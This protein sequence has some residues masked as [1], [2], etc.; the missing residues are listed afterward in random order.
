MSGPTILGVDPSLT[1]TATCGPDGQSIIKSKQTG[2]ARLH[3]I[4]DAVVALAL[5]V[6]VVYIEGYSMGRQSNALLHMGEL[7]GALRLSFWR[8]NIPYVEVPPSTL[9]KF[10]TG[11]GNANKDLVVSAVTHRSGRMFDSNDAVDAYALWCLGMA[12]TG[13]PHD[14]GD[15]P[16]THMA[17]L[18]KLKPPPAPIH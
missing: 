13:Q 7:G 15:L 18:D 11:K 16:Q 2:P 9:K 4:A 1:A 14:L 10:A 12:H 8:H 3:E 6:D 17:A 5:A